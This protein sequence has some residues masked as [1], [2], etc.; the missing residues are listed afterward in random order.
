M[1][2]RWPNGLLLLAALTALVFIAPA[3]A[4]DP[5]ID[6]FERKIRP[7]LVEHCYK[8]HSA[9]AKK[10]KGGLALDTRAGLREGGDTGPAI[11]PGKPN[12]SLLLK[13]VRYADKELR[14]PPR[15]KLPATVIADL[16]KWVAM[17]AP[18]PRGTGSAA[19]EKKAIDLEAGRRFWAF[20]PP[21][22]RPLPAVKDTAWPHG[23]IDHFL[24][25]RLEAK[26]LKPAGDADRAVLLRR[27][28]FDLVGLPP[29]PEEIAAFVNDR[30]PDAFARVVDRLLAAPQFGERWGR[31]WL[32]VARFAES[33]GGGRSLLFKDAWRYRD[34]VIEAF[35]R[36]RPYN[37]FVAEQVAGDL[38]P[39]NT[40][41]ERRRQLTATAFLALGPTNYERQNKDL[42]EMDVIDEQLDT[43]GRAFLGMTIGCARCH[44]H[45]FDPIP[46][47]DYYALAGI[48]KSTRTLIH[49]NVS[50]WVEQPLPL[51]PTQE[52]AVEKHEAAVAA[53]KERIK[54]A[55][56]W[57]KKNGIVATAR[58]T[59]PL[60]EVP[61]IVVDD[62]DA[63]Q[64]GRW[65]H[66][67]YS[68]HFIGKGYLHDGNTAKGRMTLTF[69]PTFA[70]AGRYEVR[71]AFLPASNRAARVP[72]TILHADGETSLSVN[73][74]KAPP[75]D[76][77]FVSLGTFR[78]EQG[79]QGFVMLSNEGT[80]GHVVADA[81]QFLPE[82]MVRASKAA[83]K[84][85]AGA[86][87]KRLEAD[88]KRLLASGP[89]RP[90]AMGVSEAARIEDCPL[91]IR[92]NFHTQGARVPRGFLQVAYLG[93][94]PTLPAKES[95]R[96]E[97]AEWL[98]GAD[99]PLTA[100]VMVNRIWH[101][102]F[103][104]GLVRTVDNFGT[105]GEAPSHPELLDYLALRFARDGWSV[106]KLIRAIMLSRAYQLASRADPQSAAADPEN[107][108]VGHMNRRRLDAEAIRDAILAVS[109]R[110]DLTVGGPTIKP[111][112]AT[113]TGYRFDDRRRS[114]YTPV[115]RNRL[116]EL[117]EAFDFADPNL[118]G[119]RRNVSTV[120]TQA[121]YLM[122]NPFVMDQARYAAAR[123]LAWPRLDE[124]GRL[125]R[126]YRLALGRPPTARERKLALA[127]VQEGGEKATAEQRLAAWAR[128]YQVLF[129]CM[130][131]RYV[132]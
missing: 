89:A 27:A 62:A 67:T 48:M 9:E 88:L 63:K 77:R 91:C 98:A 5:S 35:N 25:A 71:L 124:A 80:T 69:I 4:A 83:A 53:L 109:G 34:Y 66:S 36:D 32:D 93:R 22:G 125:A 56:A 16:E 72:V 76:D 54:Q 70:R 115:F 58:G 55:R 99:N 30:S 116:L 128:F 18:D 47:R 26:G 126:A 21:R 14:M 103:G 85:P 43:M 15:A 113:E 41:E 78:F 44:D 104:Q 117:F 52:A 13:A 38:L 33:S 114:V 111:G 19:A 74:Q 130:D 94:T 24:L 17:G 23:P 106:K 97:L 95:G 3:P 86:G 57:E 31:H 123:A 127:F 75:I 29:T 6:F 7:V 129:A 112:T 20:Q 11:V 84:K 51:R 10:R 2:R 81:V 107:R 120:A 82:E 100:R 50:R 105:T 119:G 37:R 12:D 49:D 28:T 68:G 121:L 110:L 59:L 122:N 79:S 46:T 101:H 64:V 87:S 132:N 40:P 45:K 92:G 108:L 42:L 60:R 90:V 102:L 118:V 131:F 1:P 65:V 8:C 96:R 39:Y 61:G 73:E